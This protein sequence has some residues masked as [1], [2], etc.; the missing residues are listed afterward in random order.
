MHI[1]W[2][3]KW[4][5][6]PP[7]PGDITRD[8]TTARPQDS[9]STVA[10]QNNAGEKDSWGYYCMGWVPR[11][12]GGPSSPRSAIKV[13]T[14]PSGVLFF[15]PGNRPREKRYPTEP[16]FSPFWAIF[17]PNRD[18]FRGILTVAFCI[19]GDQLIYQYIPSTHAHIMA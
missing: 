18:M 17:G 15:F 1:L 2:H 5:S 7:P 10:L 16:S 8:A 9:I 13:L 11:G 14:V 12:V 4:C 19:S 3:E 6:A